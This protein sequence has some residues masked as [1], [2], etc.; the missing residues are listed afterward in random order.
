M[1]FDL[2]IVRGEVGRVVEMSLKVLALLKVK[3]SPM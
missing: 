3:C 2:G 1:G